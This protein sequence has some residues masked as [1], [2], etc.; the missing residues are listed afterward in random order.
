[1]PSN[2][3]RIKWIDYARAVAII[4]VVLCHATEQVYKMNLESIVPLPL[5]SKIVCF[6]FF[7]LGRLGVPFFLMITGYL[8]LSREYNYTK[9]INFWKTKWLQLLAC[10][11]FWIAVY[12][13]FLI[14]Y[15]HKEITIKTF[16]KDI[17][18]LNKVNMSHVWYLPM[19]LGMY[20]LIPF[21]AS[22]VKNYDCRLFIFPVLFYTCYLFGSATLNTIIRV[23]NQFSS[24]FSG[25]VYGIYI[26]C[27]YFI[28]KDLLKRI[29]TF[30][31]M[32]I[33]IIGFIATVYLQLL[34]YFKGTVYNVWYDNLFLFITSFCLFELSSRIKTYRA[35]NVIKEISH[36]SF[37]IYL[38]HNIVRSIL[39]DK[40]I[41]LTP[42]KPLQTL[43]LLICCFGYGL[44]LSFII[45]KIPKVG[46][47]VLFM[48]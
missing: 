25:D 5:S 19:I 22:V 33:S 37:P 41:A 15:K 18:F 40:I 32:L 30:A 16:L 9:I 44:L 31:L 39:G 24:G 17:L 14:V 6:S 46:R 48:K 26:I 29:N 10:S 4:C 23:S 47:Y 11:I 12:D 34:S 21:V 36:Y 27:G 38:T 1:M 42:I 43:L 3:I 20:I 13:L 45:S 35:Y 8:L 7:T 2:P 28:S